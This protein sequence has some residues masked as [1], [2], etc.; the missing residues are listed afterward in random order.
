MCSNYGI[1]QVIGRV[2]VS[3]E[4]PI[5]NNNML[6]KYLKIPRR[7]IPVSNCLT[8]CTRKY[9][10]SYTLLVITVFL[11]QELSLNPS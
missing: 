3:S 4:A 10:N 2:W 5:P 9:S 7:D 11:V 8:Q 6:K 1:N